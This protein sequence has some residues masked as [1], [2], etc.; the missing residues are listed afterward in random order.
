MSNSLY[1]DDLSAPLNPKD[2]MSSIGRAAGLEPEEDGGVF[3]VSDTLLAIPRGVAGAA[4]DLYGLAD[5]VTG[6]NLPDWE[7]NP[8]GES[9]TVVGGITE[10]IVNFATGF[11][12]V[13]G[14]LSKAGKVGKAAEEAARVGKLLGRAVDEVGTVRKIATAAASNPV[15]R[16]FI[17]GAAAD[18]AVFD[19]HEGRLSDLVQ[20]FP[21]LQNPITEFLASDKDDGEIEGRLKAA[22]EGVGIGAATELLLLGVKGLKA[23]RKVKAEG[24]TDEAAEEA[25]QAAVPEPA[26]KRALRVAG[27]EENEGLL[28]SLDASEVKSVPRTVA[29]EYAKKSGI[30]TAFPDINE[31]TINED[32]S[33]K[34]A[35][36]YHAAKHDPT[37]P[38]VQRSY[39]S[40]KEDVRKQYKFLTEEKG[41]R[42]ERWTGKGEPYANSA[43]MVEDIAQNNHLFF[44]PTGTSM[45]ASH[46]LAE[47]LGTE[48]VD[49]GGGEVS[50]ND[51]FRVVHD[52]FGHAAEGNQFGA[53]GEEVAWRLHSHLFSK[54]SLPALT[55]ETRGQ[56]S[57]VNF[58]PHMRDAEGNLIRKGQPGYVE[59]PG[60]PFAE[61]KATILPSG[62]IK[63][64]KTIQE[65]VADMRNRA[66]NLDEV[67]ELGTG[68]GS[69]RV[70]AR[71]K[72]EKVI[73]D[74]TTGKITS[75]EMA[76]RVAEIE[77]K[78][79]KQYAK[80]VLSEPL[81]RVRGP[82]MVRVR[83]AEAARL[84]QITEDGRK[85]ATWLLDKNPNLANE[86]T[87]K[88]SKGRAAGGAL[89]SYDQ[90]NS[91]VTLF[92]K[93]QSVDPNTAVH[94]ILHHTERMLPADVQA[95]IKNAWRAELADEIAAATA[96]GETTKAA[97]LGEMLKIGLG[98]Y[99][100]KRYSKLLEQAF[101]LSG[102]NVKDHYHL[103]GPSEFWAVRGTELLRAQQLAGDSWLGKAKLWFKELFANAKDF[104]G[105]KNDSA[106]YK[107]IDEL[108]TSKGELY[109]IDPSTPLGFRRNKMLTRLPMERGG[110]FAALAG[111]AAFDGSAPLLREIGLSD[112][113][114]RGILNESQNVRPG[115]FT[116]AL[117]DSSPAINPRDLA[118]EEKFLLGLKNSDMNWSRWDTPE[119][120]GH[121]L[122]LFDQLLRTRFGGEIPTQTLVEQSNKAIETISDLVGSNNQKS[123]LALLGRDLQNAAD[124]RRRALA[125][126][127]VL[128][129]HTR[130]VTNLAKSIKTVAVGDA[131]AALLRLKKA[132]EFNGQ[133]QFGVKALRN[134]QGR[135]LGSNRVRIGGVE[136]P[137]WMKNAS[138]DPRVLKEELERAGGEQHLKDLAD[139]IEIAS[140][141]GKKPEAITKIARAV[142][143]N[144][145]LN[146]LIEYWMNALLGGPKTMVVNVIG[147]VLNSIYLPLE[148]LV[149]ASALRGSAGLA[150]NTPLVL[151]QQKVMKDLVGSLSELM[152][153]GREAMTAVRAMGLSGEGLLTG[154]AGVL[155]PSR[156]GRDAITA[157]NAGL[158]P[159]STAGAAVDWIGKAVRIPTRI[160]GTSDEFV[161]QMN[162]RARAFAHFTNEALEKGLKG[163]A[164]ISHVMDSMDRMVWEHQAYSKKQV[165]N[166]ATKAA[167]AEG[168]SGAEAIAK[169]ADEII[170]EQK[171]W[172]PR[173]NELSR[174][175][176][177]HANEVTFTT[178][179]DPASLSAKLQRAVHQHP[180][181]RLVV[182]FVNT[183]LNLIRFTAE[184]ANPLNPMKAL[185][186]TTFPT[187]AA[188]LNE[189]RS[190]VLRDFVSNDP[191][192]KASAIGKMTMGVSI[193]SFVYVKA[194]D[195]TITGRGPSDPEQR[196]TL[197][198][199]GWQP[200]SIRTADGYVSY[201]R[202][203]PF[204]TLIG[205]MADIL[206]YARF[207]PIEDQGKLT[208]LASG[209]V[210]SMAN[211][212]TNKSY[213]TGLSNFVEVLEQPDR[214][215]Q[216]YLQRMAGSFVPNYLG[217]A[218]L[219]SG[220][221]DMNDVRSIL[222]AITNRI[223]GLS[224]T[225]PPERNALGE[226]V[227]RVRGAGTEAIGRWV[228][229]FQP[230]A[231]REV[232]DDVVKQEMAN[233]RH[234]FTPPKSTMG[235]I[236]L[237]EV[238]MPSGQ[239]AYDRW[240]EL[241]GTVSVEG[242]TLKEALRREIR[243][244]EY[245]Q[246]S[247]TSTDGFDSPRISRINSILREYRE[248]AKK[249][250]LRESPDL[251]KH[252]QLYRQ[253]RKQLSRGLDP[254]ILPP[255]Q[256]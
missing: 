117:G 159:K 178:P 254:R 212:F 167:V 93:G 79:Q 148:Q 249:Q 189:S 186:A 62:E 226:P 242:K 161:K 154:K 203:D 134:E 53:R 72:I 141:G 160:L 256:N 13:A 56:N 255:T 97:A 121:L 90:F 131:P 216:R 96:R 209:I 236:D 190:R 187:T 193:S 219:P 80:R 211:N 26:L 115:E 156:V 25:A 73:D 239:N 157:A 232:S 126:A 151:A 123:M 116:E 86:L 194:M 10:G 206:D 250:L 49:S 204:A 44:L 127:F 237:R 207:A 146:M 95:G 37:D 201:A 238:S 136:M 142:E 133:L 20:Q 18:F 2:A 170:T 120:A 57:W 113:D 31:V 3:S 137:E 47:K 181:L 124:I 45:D 122:G 241:T 107:G 200:Y 105:L 243:S 228:D 119:D 39:A 24:G 145:K 100:W 12:P 205:S 61:Q 102:L 223:P 55:T 185:L 4:Q 128:E 199:A 33:R 58:G 114:V 163:D 177:D 76:L 23:F 27:G 48:F 227:K 99:D 59:P 87:V 98:A 183:P 184:R 71:Q 164:A 196:K 70:N 15:S 240:G 248:A 6:D 132:L 169:R 129:S 221:D 69:N 252:E 217:Q 222:D 230:I 38:V 143:G 109:T 54:E 74:F 144:R 14:W 215:A 75:D 229:L 202:L 94:E 92:K 147:P 35:D 180:Y 32:I 218:V 158:D 66:A 42:V 21:S 225:L 175:F 191:E 168:V 5:T 51:M 82:E 234:G 16:G 220:D 213:L 253:T 77:G 110:R 106:L 231:Y 103:F 152:H 246:L 214:K 8:F 224:Q 67:E 64:P 149:G 188:R 171:L 195:G 233:L 36:E 81:D 138:D 208:Q 118:P 63:G 34:I 104:F 173:L 176:I 251:R 60:R 111:D 247:P 155:D 210:V 22:V 108:M 84:G 7:K 83:I 1:D 19:G 139:S 235:D 29:E 198:E 78:M 43:A 30:G 166:R 197:M 112:A 91:L 65:V 28:A 9:D 172:D 68:A 101:T 165:W 85:F 179:A 140:E 245:Q 182:P 130:H 40:L 150:G 50:Y 174:K 88:L 244:R 89:G 192:R 162:Y 153:G 52:Y 135:A 17:A 46:P 41:L 125:Y 11:I